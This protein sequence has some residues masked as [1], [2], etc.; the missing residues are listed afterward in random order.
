VIV[1]SLLMVMVLAPYSNIFIAKGIFSIN[2][3][4]KHSLI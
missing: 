3:Y 4:I 1:I 2:L